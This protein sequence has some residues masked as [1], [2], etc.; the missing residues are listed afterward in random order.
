MRYR[1]NVKMLPGSP[2]L[3]FGIRRTVVFV[4]GCFWDG[5]DCAHGSIRAKR[6]AVYWSAKIA[7]N[8]LRDERK[9]DALRQAGWIVDV[10]WECQAQDDR[11]LR[12][13]ASRL[14]R[15]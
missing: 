4:H 14:K 11:Y 15:R 1:T 10:V 9:Y 8:R 13:L 6:N 12:A 3:V 7:D 5:H 2:G